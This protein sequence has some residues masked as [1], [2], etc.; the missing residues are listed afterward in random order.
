VAAQIGSVAKLCA[1]Y[2]CYACAMLFKCKKSQFDTP[3]CQE[4]N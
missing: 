4:V 1:F 2:V 3:L